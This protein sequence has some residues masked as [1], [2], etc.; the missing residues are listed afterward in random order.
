MKPHPGPIGAC[1]LSFQPGPCSMPHAPNVLLS[2]PITACLQFNHPFNPARILRNFLAVLFIGPNSEAILK[3]HCLEASLNYE[4]NLDKILRWNNYAASQENQLRG[5]VA[6]SAD[7]VGN[8][9]GPSTSNK[10]GRPTGLTCRAPSIDRADLTAISSPCTYECEEPSKKTYELH[11]LP[12]PIHPWHRP[13]D[14][15]WLTRAA[16]MHPSLLHLPYR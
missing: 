4:I 13:R 16:C 10:P 6:V 5:L 11:D 14:V 1:D 7:V 3:M 12:S 15:T 2:E 9:F 8:S